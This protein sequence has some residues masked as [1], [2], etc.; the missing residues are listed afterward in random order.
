MNITKKDYL[1]LIKKAVR[2]D[3]LNQG[4]ITS[5]AIFKD[6]KAVFKLLS[7]DNGVL[8]GA[9]IFTDVFKF[10]DNSLKVDF[11]FN[12]K[13]N[14]KPKQIVARVTGK[15]S[16]ILKGER[17]GLNFI[18][19]LS[20]IA[21]KTALFV[22]ESKNK[23]KI[24]DTRKTLPGYRMLQKYAVYCGGGMNHR[25]GLYDMVLIKDNHIDAS[26][27]ITDAINKVRLKW[28]NKFKIEVETRNLNEVKEALTAQADIIM[29]D[30]MDIKT[31][32]QAVKLIN[33]KAKSE[34][35]GN[36]NLKRIKEITTTGADYVSIGELTHSVKI[37][38]FSLKK[39]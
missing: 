28:K 29:L 3:N 16:S 15:V 36:V 13:D 25:I 37:F 34:V 31:M 4:D 9:Q 12:D 17:I 20:G 33:G 8:C 39:E 23:I 14:L 22:K 24:L 6:E 32:K 27:S 38:D 7:K 1:Y 5:K 26:G 11:Y 2:E 30:N 21:S 18:S 35:S 19:H 10:I